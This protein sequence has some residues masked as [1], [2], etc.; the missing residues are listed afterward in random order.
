M[1]EEVG[2]S[3]PVRQ[4]Q[5]AV[6]VPGREGQEQGARQ[7]ASMPVASLLEALNEG[8]ESTEPETFEVTEL[9]R[10]FEHSAHRLPEHAFTA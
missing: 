10:D 2:G 8:N 1:S 7:A 3:F 9:T 4:G 6:P 5:K